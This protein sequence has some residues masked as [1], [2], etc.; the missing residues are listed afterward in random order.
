M[1]LNAALYGSAVLNDQDIMYMYQYV[2]NSVI[3]IRFQPRTSTFSLSYE[4]RTARWKFF[5][6]YLTFNQLHHSSAVEISELRCDWLT[7]LLKVGI[8]VVQSYDSRPV[9]QY[10]RKKIE[11]LG[12]QC[13]DY[14]SVAFLNISYKCNKIKLYTQNRILLIAYLISVT[15][16]R[17]IA[18]TKLN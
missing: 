1:I 15:F 10:V 12:F 8:S 6:F 4:R 11:E 13:Y 3:V 2:K 17:E 9:W 7:D 16:S 14:M 18:E 5:T